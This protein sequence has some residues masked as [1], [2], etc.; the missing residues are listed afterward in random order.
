MSKLKSKLLENHLSS[1][2]CYIKYIDTLTAFESHQLMQEFIVR[3]QVNSSKF[4]HESPF[5][6]SFHFL[7]VSFTINSKNENISTG[8]FTKKKHHIL[9]RFPSVSPI[10]ERK[11]ATVKTDA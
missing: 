8:I 5:T 4:T 6:D 1:S 3:F 11:L 7:D 9:L 10:K 2:E